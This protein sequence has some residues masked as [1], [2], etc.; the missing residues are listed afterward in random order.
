MDGN[1]KE[2]N[3]TKGKGNG[4]WRVGEMRGVERDFGN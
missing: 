4:S 2:G 1:R 3:G